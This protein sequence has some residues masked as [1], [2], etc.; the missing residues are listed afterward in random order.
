MLPGSITAPASAVD[1]T[2]RVVVSGWHVFN[3]KGKIVESYEPFFS[4]GWDFQLEQEAA[5]GTYLSLFYDPRGQLIRTVNPNG[6]EQRIIFG[7]PIDPLQLDIAVSD[8]DAVP[9]GFWPSPWESYTYDANDLAAVTQAPDG[10]SL[11][12]RA[13]LNHHFTPAHVVLDSLGRICCTVACNGSDPSK[14]WLI[15]R[16]AYDIRGNLLQLIDPL[17]RTAFRYC[18]DLLDRPIAIDSIDAGRRTSVLD[19]LDCLIEYRD[20]KGSLVQ[21][22]YDTLNRPKELW[23]RD[24]FNGAF[25]LRERIEYGDEGDRQI[26]RRHNTLGRPTK[27]FDEAGLLEMSDY[28][29]KGNL[30]EKNRLSIRDDRLPDWKAD[31]RIPS[32]AGGPNPQEALETTAYRVSSRYDALNRPLEMSYPQDLD[33]ERKR[34]TPYYN[35]AGAL[36]ALDLEGDI[37]VRRISY[38]AKGQ[39]I[40]VAYGNGMMTRYAY[41]EATYRLARLRTEN[42]HSPVAEPPTFRPNGGVLQDYSYEYDLIG[43]IIRID[44]RTARCGTGTD[45]DRLR[46]VF[47]YDP[48]YRL[49]SATGRACKNIATPRGFGD[50]PRC[51]FYA[52]GSAT[53]TQTNAPD[54][55]EAYTE[56]FSYDPAGNMLR[57]HYS[58]GSGQWTRR[59]GMSGFTPRQW[60]DRLDTAPAGPGGFGNEGNRLTNV[61]G[62]NQV[63]NYDFDANGNLS[64]QN[65]AQHYIWDHANR[66]VGY[67]VQANAASPPSLT[68]RYLYGADGVRV[69]KWVS[70]QGG[71]K[72]TTTTYIDGVFERHHLNTA[73]EDKANDNL[74][75]LNRKSRVAIVR[76]GA[77]LSPSDASPQVGYHLGDHLDSTHV[78]VGGADSGESSFINREE[79]FPYGET[80]FGSFGRKRY[81][82]SG[83]ERDEESGLYY[84]GARYLAPWLAR[85]VS[86]DPAWT[87]DSL[88]LYLSLKLSPLVFYNS[89]GSATRPAPEIIGEIKGL[90]GQLSEAEQK[91]KELGEQLTRAET[92][93]IKIQQAQQAGT[94]DREMLEG[95]ELR[96]ETETNTLRAQLEQAR[97]AETQVA[98]NLDQA[99]LELET[100]YPEAAW[101]LKLAESAD[102]EQ[103][104]VCE[105]RSMSSTKLYKNKTNKS[106]TNK[107]KMMTMMVAERA[108]FLCCRQNCPNA[109]KR[110]PQGQPNGHR[111]ANL[112]SDRLDYLWRSYRFSGRRSE[113]GVRYQTTK[114]KCTSPNSKGPDI[115]ESFKPEGASK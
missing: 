19:A 106:Q 10:T 114:T 111:S 83:Q 79:Y 38:N 15:T 95:V 36:E 71:G 62:E 96:N 22:I 57:L 6:T 60:N 47:A 11:A 76:V 69:K 63:R 88:D 21:R 26:A 70:T 30:L 4:R 67:V 45:P 105:M 59:F 94:M 56:N 9:A 102:A 24:D 91:S 32:S 82:Y 66:M 90:K 93:T 89:Q 35:R 97:Q 77:P 25:T 81:R 99:Q 14:D 52:G 55:T 34:L 68:A 44:D 113:L 3:N 53:T 1:A 75:V 103:I 110:N 98:T 87:V 61:G 8:Y 46:R 12:S 28:D 109:G 39:R 86:C 13:P 64:G 17:G 115:S 84:Y 112:R 27:H 100:D 5:K 80:S 50:D 48:I 40:L 54:L 18:Y 7:A 78:V 16:P 33:G 23:A 37:Y 73:S 49:L 74:H 41:D 72:I 58:A 20:S 107:S 104:E 92:D 85:W 51:G 43:N 101:E 2:D 31:W 42:F 29:F 65:T 108:Y